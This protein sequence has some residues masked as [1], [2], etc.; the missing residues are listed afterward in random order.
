MNETLSEYLG[1]CMCV[2]A[3]TYP[4]LSGVLEKTEFLNKTEYCRRNITD[5]RCEL[6]VRGNATNSGLL[7]KGGMSGVAV[8]ALLLFLGAGSLNWTV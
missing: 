2:N 8:G 6:N 1:N 4:D 7:V 5:P 3:G